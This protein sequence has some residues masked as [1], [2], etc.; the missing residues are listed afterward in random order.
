MNKKRFVLA[1]ITLTAIIIPFVLLIETYI[2]PI[3]PLFIKIA[4]L[5]F[6]IICIIIFGIKGY[7]KYVK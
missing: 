7:R 1:M 6:I 3:T 2:A 4:F 5:V